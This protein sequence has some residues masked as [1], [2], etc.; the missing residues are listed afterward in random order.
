MASSTSQAPEGLAALLAFVPR[1]LRAK[2]VGLGVL[3]VGLGGTAAA[4]LSTHRLYRSEA[5]ITYDRGMANGVNAPAA[6]SPRQVGSRIQDMFSSRQRLE[7]IIKE[8]KLY[9]KIVDRL[10]Y[11]DAVEEMRAH[12][13]VGLRESLTFRISFDGDDRDRAQKVLT[14]LVNSVVEED[15]ER[16]KREAEGAKNFLDTER[17]NAD[18]DLRVKES[19]LASFLSKHPQL[20][21]EAAATTGGTI[22]AADRERDTGPVADVA[23]LEVQSAHIEEAIAAVEKPRGP[24]G[25]PTRVYDPALLA[26]QTRAAADLHAARQDLK[27]KQSRFTDDHPDVKAAW[28]RA[29][30][31]EAAARQAD[32]ALAASATTTSTDGG[33]AAKDD[34]SAQSRTA[35]L[36]RALAAVRSQIAA[37]SSR[38][39]PRPDH[40]QNAQA[41][42]NVDTDWTRLARA[43][44]EARER[45]QQLEA[46]QFQAQLTATLVAAGQAGGFTVTDPPF[47]PT[48]PVSGGRSKI[49]LA[50]GGSSLLLAILAMFIVGSLDTRLYDSRDIS[51]VVDADIEVL[52]IPKLTGKVG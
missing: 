24:D 7:A 3:L 51:Q 29:K 41:M 28:A 34:A 21:G 4:A 30:E 14:A 52:V 18:E 25:R 31:A 40:S 48:R 13:K 32:A 15:I 1:A 26:A 46:K 20:A 9:P 45:Q 22:R 27:D 50:G 36:R 11:V 37:A 10:G 23:A 49:V 44:D 2:W 5:V 38:R 19:A 35:A 33:G 16:R 43:T 12:I 47:R 17:K 8:M 42:I 39:A 6:E